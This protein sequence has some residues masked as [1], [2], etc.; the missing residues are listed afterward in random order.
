MIVSSD[1]AGMK[2]AM[3]S[4][5]TL[6]SENAMGMPEN[7]KTSVTAPNRVPSISIDISA[8]LARVRPGARG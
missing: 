1:E 3:N 2:T 5:P 7:M 6:P 8:L 4:T